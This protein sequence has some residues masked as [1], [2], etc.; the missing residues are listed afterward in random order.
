VVREA[1]N[2]SYRH[3]D[4]NGQLVRASVSSGS[5]TVVVSDSG[6]DQPELRDTVI[7]DREL[8][9]G[10]DGLRRVVEELDGSFEVRSEGNGT[11][12]SATISVTLQ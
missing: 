4:G 6:P 8:S 1:L 11:L 5:I 9:L 10:L 2:N 7:F 12:V 3:A